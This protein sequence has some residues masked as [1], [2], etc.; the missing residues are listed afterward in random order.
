[1]IKKHKSGCYKIT[2]PIYLVSFYLAL[3]NKYADKLTGDKY[4]VEMGMVK[5]F[6][7]D[8]PLMILVDKTHEVISHEITHVALILMHKL[9]IYPSYEDQEP[10]AYI[11]G[12]IA[13]HVYKCLEREDG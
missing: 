5:E 8:P 2:L 7:G 13:E 1:M 10:M 4:E 9:G 12:Y 6:D 3:D 11:M